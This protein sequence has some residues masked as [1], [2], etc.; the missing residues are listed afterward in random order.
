M[1]SQAFRFDPDTHKYFINDREAVSVTTLLKN[2][3]C[4]PHFK[5]V[6]DEHIWRGRQIHDMMELYHR[7]TL[8][9]E[10]L[11]ELIVPYH[12][13]WLKFEA[14]TGF[15][16]VGFEE[17]LYHPLLMVGGKPDAWGLCGQ[18]IWI[19]DYKHGIP[20][21]VTGLQLAGY[22]VLLKAN[23]RIDT[24]GRRVRRIGLQLKSDGDYNIIP[25]D[26]PNDIN[27]WMMMVSIHNW[28]KNHVN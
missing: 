13:G 17:E 19:I 18:E 24:T 23:N 16:M 25:F 6:T 14:E 5:Y 28:R 1:N 27:I 8:D 12:R 20:P 7:G 2:N 3:G 10:A 26:D 21:R 22:E 15:K 9:L 11:D 4:Y